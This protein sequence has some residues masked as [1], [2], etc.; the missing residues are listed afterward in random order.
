MIY[1][2][3][4][5]SHPDPIVQEIRAM[6]ADHACAVL[7][8]CGYDVYSP[9]SHWHTIAKKHAL[10]GDAEYWKQ[11]NR[12]HMEHSERMFVVGIPGWTT[13]YGL[14]YEFDYFNEKDKRF[15]VIPW[16]EFL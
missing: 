3:T 16:E 10:R 1:L 8:S 11:N 9:I 12:H 2:A 14:G 15:T 13:S 4:P 6:I 7:Q 5:Y